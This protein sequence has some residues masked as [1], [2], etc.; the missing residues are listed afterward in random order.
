M[1]KLLL[2]A[3]PLQRWLAVTKLYGKLFGKLSAIIISSAVCSSRSGRSAV[4]LD[5]SGQR[6]RRRLGAVRHDGSGRGAAG[7]DDDTCDGTRQRAQKRRAEERRVQQWA[8]RSPSIVMAAGVALCRSNVAGALGRP[9]NLW[10]GGARRQSKTAIV[11]DLVGRGAAATHGTASCQDGAECARRDAT[12][13]P[14][15]H[16]AGVWRRQS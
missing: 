11:L 7:R 15:R 5:S 8:R 16:S 2:G 9:R 4:G 14:W 3:Q 12:S 6:A 10:N 13:W 1:T